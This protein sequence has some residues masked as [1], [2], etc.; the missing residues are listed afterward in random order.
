M[1]T[2]GHVLGVAEWK[3]L[4]ALTSRILPSDDGAGA[5]EAS[6]MTFIDGQ[7]ATRDFSPVAKFVIEAARLLEKH[8]QNLYKTP[9]ADLDASRQDS[10][11]LTRGDRQ[12]DLQAA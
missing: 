4:E 8:A 3:V 12:S 10:D 5:R 9:F 1:A 7:L 6:V 2:S 11:I